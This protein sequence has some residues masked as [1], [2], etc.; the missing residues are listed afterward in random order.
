MKKRLK[1]GQKV[2]FVSFDPKTLKETFKKGTVVGTKCFFADE[3][4]AIA[5]KNGE[6]IEIKPSS[7]FTKW[8]ENYIKKEEE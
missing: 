2:A 6:I 1:I 5:T 8:D 7:V 4:V 3:K